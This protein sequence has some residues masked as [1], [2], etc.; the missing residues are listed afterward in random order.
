[1]DVVSL[2]AG[3]ECAWLDC[4]RPVTTEEM[5]GGVDGG[6]KSGPAV[7]RVQR[8]AWACNVSTLTR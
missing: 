5:A 4:V 1:M 6:D 2:L 3:A 7:S 8:E